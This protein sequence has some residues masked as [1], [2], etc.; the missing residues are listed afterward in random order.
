L[1]ADGGVEDI[2]RKSGKR[3]EKSGNGESGNAEDFLKVATKLLFSS[4]S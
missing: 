2:E 4:S 3:K 1:L